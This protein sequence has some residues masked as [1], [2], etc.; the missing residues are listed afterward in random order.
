MT[1]K[2]NQPMGGNEMPRFGGPGTMMRLP[3]QETA[4]GL[5]ACFI[6]VPLDIGTSNRSGTRSFHARWTAL[7]ALTNSRMRAAGRLHG[8][9]KRL[10]MCGRICVPRP[11]AK[12]PRE[13]VCR[14]LLAWATSMG[15]R[16]NATAMLLN[17]NARDVCS[18]A[19][20]SGK[21]GSCG[22]SAV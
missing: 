5:D 18:A 21:N 6:G 2:L 4:E 16:A 14:S 22:P 1:R 7:I 19:S 13:S 11:S 17:S 3:F 15:L 8:I 9:E 20:A 12:R 10:W